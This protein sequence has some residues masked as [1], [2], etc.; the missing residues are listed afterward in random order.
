MT[1]IPLVEDAREL[2]R[3][4]A[5]ELEEAGYRVLPAADGRAA[6]DLLDRERPDLAVLDWMLPG[7]GGL[8]VLRDLRR[9]RATR[10]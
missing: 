1:T 9:S 3:V 7:V 4:V 2:T 5:R 8:D 6:L 10:S